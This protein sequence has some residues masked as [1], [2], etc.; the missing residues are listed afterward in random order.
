MKGRTMERSADPRAGEEDLTAKA[1]IRNAAFD[2]FAGIGE[3]RASMRMVAASAGVTV[4]LVVHHFTSKDNLRDAVEG[5]V[6]DYFA[7]AIGSV[8]MA[9][10]DADI[11]R[12]RDAAVKAM[13]ESHP[14]V[15]NY[16][17]RALLE[18]GDPR[19]HLLERLTLLAEESVTELREQGLASTTR[20]S[21]SQV[22][23]LIV[24]QLGDLFLQPMIDTMW[25]VLE[26][27]TANIADKPVLS[28]TAL[29][30][31]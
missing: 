24:G 15:V 26:P 7:A 1:R 27:P 8:P 30:R 18:S 29:R 12:A 10:N 31:N 22:I 11:G 19:G 25:D 4:G 16:L 13:L 28:V 21:T 9:G 5:L 6:I 20:S 3:D 14:T 17:R 23:A 2:L